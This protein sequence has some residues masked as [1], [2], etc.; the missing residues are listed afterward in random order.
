MEHEVPESSVGSDPDS[1]RAKSH[2]YSRQGQTF[3]PTELVGSPWG[4]DR[5]H[6][7]PPSALL[8]HELTRAIVSGLRPAR[9]TVDLYRPVPRAPVRVE[10]RVLR[11]GRRL[12]VVEGTILS[13]ERPVSAARALFLA[14][15]EIADFGAEERLEPSPESLSGEAMIPDSLAANVP[16]GFH[17]QVEVRWIERSPAPTA[18]I[19]LPMTLFEGEPTSGFERLAAT[20]DFANALASRARPGEKERGQVGFINTDSTIVLARE[21]VGEWIALR[22]ER[23]ADRQGIGLVEATVFDQSGFVG[24]CVQCRLANRPLL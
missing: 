1:A 19:R 6:G 18:W 4:G 12:A 3:V 17:R 10:T 21:P 24:H 14:P 22:T 5:Q 9:L 13:D 8:A 2:L 20:A 23:V 11:R 7:G 16:P 15:V